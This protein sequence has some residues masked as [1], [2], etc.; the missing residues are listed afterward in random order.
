[1]RVEKLLWGLAIALAVFHFI[2]PFS[3]RTTW[4]GGGLGMMRH[5]A[6]WDWVAPL[7][8]LIVLGSLVI[9]LFNRPRILVPAICATIATVAFGATAAASTGHWYDLQ[10]G[11]LAV[12]RMNLHPA[13]MVHIFASA[14]TAG[15]AVTLILLGTWLRPGQDEWIS[16]QI[17]PQSPRL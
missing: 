3:G 17:T 7:A 6:G 5:S 13:P 16:A 12:E 15:V 10:R 1:M 11:A 9:G 4:T 2:A 14:A 8:A